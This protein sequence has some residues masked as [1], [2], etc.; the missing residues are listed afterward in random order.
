MDEVEK[1]YRYPLRRSVLKDAKRK[2]VQD[3]G[4][5]RDDLQQRV[6]ALASKKS[7]RN[8]IKEVLAEAKVMA[9]DA[10]DGKNGDG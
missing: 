6:L 1:V 2:I 5:A 4:E 10:V 7:W 9:E 3:S 8:V